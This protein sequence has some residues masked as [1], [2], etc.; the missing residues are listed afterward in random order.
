[1]PI[2]RC[3]LIF[4]EMH[5]QDG[6]LQKLT[7]RLFPV[8]QTLFFT[9]SG[10]SVYNQSLKASNSNLT[11]KLY[12]TLFTTSLQ[13]GKYALKYGT[14]TQGGAEFTVMTGS[15]SDSPMAEP[16]YRISPIGPESYFQIDKIENG[17]MNGSFFIYFYQPVTGATSLKSFECKDGKFQDLAVN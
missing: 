2:Q 10:S 14:G 4:T 9:N 3:H 13:V 11:E 15:A 1:M 8:V 17:K 7:N 12:I 16:L 6:L 5:R